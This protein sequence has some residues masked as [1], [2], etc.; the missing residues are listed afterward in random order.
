MSE[1]RSP[2]LQVHLRTAVCEPGT[3]TSHTTYPPGGI[4][5]GL[6]GLSYDHELRCVVLT[7]RD[8]DR[9]RL[10]PLENVLAMTPAPASATD[11]PK[12]AKK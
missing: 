9:P 8:Q 3:S 12:P 10:I 5:P 7:K 6:F 1:R 4:S 2:L 11:E